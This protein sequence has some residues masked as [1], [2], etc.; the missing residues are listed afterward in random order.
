M[1]QRR[2]QQGSVLIYVVIGAATLIA[3]AALSTE[4]GRAWHTKNQLQAAADSSSLAGVGNLLTNNFQTVD[5]SGAITAA[6]NM[7]GNHT[8]TGSTLGVGPPS[9]VEVGSWNLVTQTFTPLPGNTNPNQVR[10]VHVITRR[11]GVANGP[12]QTIFGQVVGMASID[13]N[14]DAVAYWG[15][16]GS[17]GIGEVDLPIA[18]DCC[19][20][21]GNTPGATCTQD[22]CTTVQANPPNPCPWAGGTTSCLEFYATPDQN[23]CWTEFDEVHPSISTPGL[24]NIVNNNNTI[25]ISGNPIYLDNGNKTPVLRDIQDRFLGNGNFAGNP[26]GSDL[27]PL[28][29]GIDSWVVR[30][31][32]VECQ[33]PGSNCSGGSQSD[34][35]GFVCFDIHEVIIS[36]GVKL[37]KG[38]FLC[39]SDPRCTNVGLGPGGTGPGGISAAYPVIVQ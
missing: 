3:L 31:P 18:I 32:V 38:D 23:A 28:V 25:P 21:S 17:A 2:R 39:S 29:P 30:L 24:S 6:T 19:A 15:F 4:T 27:D 13:V 26:A 34:I 11:D 16:A 20:I 22:Y 35:V 12:M 10:A 7:V 5:E 8:A 36:G 9:D 33:N 1:K 14:S 37:I